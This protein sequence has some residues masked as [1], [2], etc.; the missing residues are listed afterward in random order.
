MRIVMAY[1]GQKP[2][3]AKAKQV[4]NFSAESV[5]E[6]KDI[7]CKTSG[8]CKGNIYT[9]VPYTAWKMD[10]V[11]IYTYNYITTTFSDC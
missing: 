9:V 7:L 5:R 10:Y 4:Q 3:V 8:D 2:E 11:Y 6:W 1:P